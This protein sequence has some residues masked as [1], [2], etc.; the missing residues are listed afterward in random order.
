MIDDRHL[1]VLNDDDFA[2]WATSGK[3]E[4]KML[5]T[6]TVDGN[7]LYLVEVDLRTQGHPYVS[8]AREPGDV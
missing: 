1:G 3:L 2:T 7:R 4:Q 5:D 8:V 6:N